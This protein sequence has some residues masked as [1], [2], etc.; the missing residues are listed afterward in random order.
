MATGICSRFVSRRLVCL[1]KAAICRGLSS[2]PTHVDPSRPANEQ[3][4]L[5]FTPGPLTT[6]YTIKKAMTRDLGSRDKAFLQVIIDVCDGL[7]NVAGVSKDEYTTVPVQGS[8]TFGVESVITSSV[9]RNKS[10]LVIANGAYGVRITH[11][12]K[13][14]GIPFHLLE[15]AEDQQPSVS[16]VDAFLAADKEGRFSHV[17]VVHSETTSGII[18]NVTAVGQTVKKHKRRF[19]VD[20]MSSFGAVPLDFKIAGIDFL[21][22]S[23]NKCV[24]GTPGF[25]F[26]IARK[27]ALEECKG[28]ARS[29]SLDLY[30][31]RKGL[32]ASG[33]FR[34]TPPTHALLAFRQ[35]LK[36]LEQEGGPAARADRYKANQKV[37]MAGMAKLGFQLYLKPE[38]QGYIISS[39]RYPTDPNWNFNTFYNKLN[40]MDFVIYPGKVSNADCFRIGHIGRIFPADT[41]R[42]VAAIETVTKSMKTAGFYKP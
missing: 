17:A 12:C 25:S 34:F 41:E 9:P 31:Q 37:L 3:D 15:Y 11:M 18:N 1:N 16:D 23:A 33:Q 42:L 14:A 24:E 30:A 36:E 19:I 20:A 6:S 22:S 40:E 8:G 39:Y 32:D 4:R 2:I 5:L 29:L 28:V 26:A 10:L 13:A 7:L 27:D 21:V 35:A 38:N